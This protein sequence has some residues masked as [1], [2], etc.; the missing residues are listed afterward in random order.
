MATLGMPVNNRKH[1]T[2][3]TKP[4]IRYLDHHLHDDNETSRAIACGVSIHTYRKYRH[5]ERMSWITA[6]KCATRL[7]RHP[8]D[9]W[10]DWYHIVN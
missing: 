6:D 5:R 8:S 9:I 3:P 2:V 10:H 1:L 4:L 7:G